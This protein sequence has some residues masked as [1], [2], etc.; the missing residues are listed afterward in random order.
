[1]SPDVTGS[2]KIWK[3]TISKLKTHLLDLQN[4]PRTGWITGDLNLTL[5]AEVEGEISSCWRLPNLR[6]RIPWQRRGGFQD[7]GTL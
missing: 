3:Q 6:G 1:M 2:W 7:L 4:M 5:Q